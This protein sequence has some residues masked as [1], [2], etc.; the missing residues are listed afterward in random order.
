MP[1]FL[2][3]TTDE[4]IARFGWWRG[5]RL[6][7]Q[8][9]LARLLP[10]GVM[11]RADVPI[12]AYPV[13]LRAGT[14]DRQVL[15]EI[16]REPAFDVVQA[17]RP[18]FIVDA[19]ANIGLV[20]ALLATHYPQAYI[21]ALEIDPQNYRVLQR[22]VAPYP[23]VTSLHAGLWSHA[24][25]LVVENPD[26]DAW[27]FRACERRDAGNDA[28][29]RPEISVPAFDVGGLIARF[30][31]PRVDLLKVDI[32]GGEREVFG[33]GSEKWLDRVCA[34]VVELHD[35]LLP[36]C[37]RVVLGALAGRFS[38]VHSGSV[39]VFIRLDLLPHAK[40]IPTS[41]APSRGAP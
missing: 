7:L 33:A 1:A 16:L 21:I 34:I 41:Q 11:V 28:A 9:R 24:T 29:H 35:R 6:A 19:G 14:S 15:R 25:E 27:A 2:G 8:L 5:L 17:I 40:S 13:F 3:R 22:N 18:D 30:G 23:R 20:S 39:D 37:S 38:H 10:K 32:E 36:D 4:M 31:L 26:A 12:F